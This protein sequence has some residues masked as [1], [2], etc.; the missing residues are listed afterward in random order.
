MGSALRAALLAALMSA[1][2]QAIATPQQGEKA[3]ARALQ[4]CAPATYEAAL[5]CLDSVLPARDQAELARPDGAIDAHFGLGLFLRNNWGLWKSGALHRS[6][7]A[8]G[9]RHPDDMSA[10]IL[11]GFAARER[12]EAYRP[13][14]PDPAQQAA[15]WDQLVREGRAGSV[16]CDPPA[17]NT[18]NK[19]QQA[20]MEACFDQMTKS[21]ESD[22]N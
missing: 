18:A 2:V 3:V 8:M 17:P 6:M 16:S 13:S 21:L 7:A 22:P 14:P 11:E 12:G 1:P 5:D 9:F 10:A 15:E 19:N 20:E 4:R